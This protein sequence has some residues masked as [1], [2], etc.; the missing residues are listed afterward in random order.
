MIRRRWKVILLLAGMGTVGALFLL[1]YLGERPLLDRATPVVTETER[2]IQEYGGYFWI[3]NRE[4]LSFRQVGR[5]NVQAYR[6]DIA[7]GGARPLLALNRSLRGTVTDT[8]QWRLSPDGKWLVWPNLRTSIPRWVASSLD[9]SRTITW[10]VLGNRPSGPLWLPGNNRWVEFAF[11]GYNGAQPWIHN[12]D[13]TTE[14]GPL[15]NGAFR[16]PMGITATARVVSLEMDSNEAL[17]GDTYSLVSSSA[18][19][20]TFTISLPRGTQSTVEAELSPQGDRLAYLLRSERQS[21]IQRFL[22]TLIPGV[23]AP[24]I[25]QYSLWVSRLDGSGAHRIGDEEGPTVTGLLWTPDGK[26]L[27]FFCNNNLYTIPAD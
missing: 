26:R 20:Q 18:P 9:D 12:L 23:D 15:I 22:H 17:Q 7:T 2:W 6:V 16:W 14:R 5:G 19:P 1:L 27:S 4:I 24:T 21:A 25:N 11:V 8:A 10:P 13:G 3:S